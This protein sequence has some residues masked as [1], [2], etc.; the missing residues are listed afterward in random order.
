MLRITLPTIAL[1]FLLL[2]GVGFAYKN[3]VEENAVLSERVATLQEEV[4]GRDFLL[5]QR[6]AE[7]DILNNTLEEVSEG[8]QKIE[9]SYKSLKDELRKK[10]CPAIEQETSIPSI[11]DELADAKR[12]LDRAHCLSDGSCKPSTSPSNAVQGGTSR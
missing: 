6:A 1:L 12:L 9:E 8:K 3:K 11:D 5:Q 10:R 4:G 2:L 7:K